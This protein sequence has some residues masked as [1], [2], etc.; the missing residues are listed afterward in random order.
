MRQG[1]KV[2]NVFKFILLA[3]IFCCA[4]G[5]S[6]QY[7]WNW[8]IP[9]LFHGPYITFW[10]ALGLCLLG[11]LLFGWHG[12]GAAPWSARAKQK[13]RAKMVARMEHMSEEEKEKLREKFRKCSIGGRWGH[14]PFNE[15]TKQPNSETNL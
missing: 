13:W 8:L 11:K 10:Q 14:N 1:S 12:G 5:F 2:V 9:E 7:L 4:I 15:E 6:V 3:F